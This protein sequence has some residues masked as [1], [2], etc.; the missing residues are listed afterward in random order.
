MPIPAPAFN[1]AQLLNDKLTWDHITK[2][3]R[4]WQTR[5]GLESDGKAGDRETLPH[6]E[7][8]PVEALPDGLPATLVPIEVMVQGEP[9]KVYVEEKT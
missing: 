9:F 3:V 1:A 8:T 4:F 6:L 7:V 5:H 2:L